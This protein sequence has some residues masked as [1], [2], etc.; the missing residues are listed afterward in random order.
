M[1]AQP[2][3]GKRASQPLKW[4][5]MRQGSRS[6]NSGIRRSAYIIRR[7][8]PAEDTKLS[9]ARR[10]MQRTSMPGIS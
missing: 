6:S 5:P 4:E 2:C 8:L 10:K 1:V 9:G 7:T 3:L